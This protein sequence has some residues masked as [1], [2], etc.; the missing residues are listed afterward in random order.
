VTFGGSTSIRF[1]YVNRIENA[2]NP[3][4]PL[5]CTIFDRVEF[6]TPADTLS[7]S[8]SCHNAVAPGAS[9]GYVVVSAEDPR[10]FGRSWSFN[11]L[12]GSAIVVTWTGAIYSTEAIPFISPL[13]PGA[14]TDLN[15]NVRLDFDGVEYEAA[16]EFLIV[17]L[18][19]PDTRSLSQITL[20]NLTG[21]P[22]AINTVYLSVWNDDEVALS[23]TLSFSCHLDRSFWWFGPLF[24]VPYFYFFPNNPGELDLNCDGVG[25]LETGWMIVDSIDVSMPSGLPI[26][27]DGALVGSYVPIFGGELLWESFT[28]Q[29]NGQFR[30]P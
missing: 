18:F 2:A 4:L 5:G 10:A 7:V 9:S 28:R 29:N 16:P 25:D 23:A 11:F 19:V 14:A 3:L 20:I 15:G 8:T 30:T 27:S 12:V 13:A 17:P 26:A 6:L 22:K 1:E 21:G 24:E